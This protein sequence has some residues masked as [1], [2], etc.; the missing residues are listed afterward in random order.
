VAKREL[1]GAVVVIT[2]AAGGIGSAIAR[3]LSEA[4]LVLIDLDEH[5]LRSLA[6]SLPN[7]PLAVSCDV[8][9]PGAV[10]EAFTSIL[11]ARGGVDVLINNAGITHRSA[12]AGTNPDVLRRVMNVNFLGA[13]HCTASALPSIL[14]RRGALVAIGSVAGFAPL[15]GRSGYVASKHALHGFFETLRTELR[16]TGVDVTIVAPTFVDTPIRTHALGGDGAIID[17]PQS[18]VD[19]MLSPERVAGAVVHAVTHRRRLVVL[20]AVGKASHLLMRIAPALF[21]RIMSWSL[22]SDDR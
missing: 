7:E 16:H 14:E 20:G 1:E 17:H 9:D 15:L 11:E 4:R 6:D 13:V 22:T 10:A 19:S 3:Q 5:R 8:T 18:R 12:F 21:E 2:G